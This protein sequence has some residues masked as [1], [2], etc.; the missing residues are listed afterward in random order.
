MKTIQAANQSTAEVIFECT[1]VHG[2][3]SFDLSEEDVRSA[4]ALGLKFDRLEGEAEGYL[5]PVAIFVVRK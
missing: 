1:Y 5:T 2:D 3:G 4:E